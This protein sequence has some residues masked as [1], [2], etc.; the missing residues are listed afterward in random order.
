MTY[1]TSI[2]RL[3]IERGKIIGEEIGEAKIVQN[4]YRS[5]KD[6]QKVA[7]LCRLSLK[8]VRAIIGQEKL[9]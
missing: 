2:E 1:V 8:K 5:V 3:G 4:L 6:V 7:T 9:R